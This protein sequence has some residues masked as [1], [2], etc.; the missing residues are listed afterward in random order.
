MRAGTLK[1]R[2]FVPPR[3]KSLAAAASRRINAIEFL[4]AS[5][6]VQG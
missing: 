1:R 3:Q 2:P 4:S 5:R 6:I